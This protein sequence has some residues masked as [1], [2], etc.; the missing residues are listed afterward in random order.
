MYL[1]VGYEQAILPPDKTG[2]GWIVTQLLDT[3]DS[4][5]FTSVP[6]DD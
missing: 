2:L 3:L 4:G 5:R 1:V 6:G